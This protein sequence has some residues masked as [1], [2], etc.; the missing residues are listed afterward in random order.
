MKRL[1]ALLIVTQFCLMGLHAQ[2]DSCLTRLAGFAKNISNFN[3]LYPQEKVYLHF[4]NTGY[5]LGDTIWFKAYVVSAVDLVPAFQSKVVYVELLTPEGRVLATRKLKVEDGQCHGEF[6]LDDDLRSG[7]YEVRAYTRFMLNF[8]LGTLFSRVFPV[9]KEPEFDGDYAQRDMKEFY[10]NIGNDNLRQRPVEKFDKV[11]VTFFPEGGHLVNGIPSQVAFKATDKNGQGIDVTG[12]VLNDRNQ[13]ITTFASLHH[14]MGVFNVCPDS[15]NFKV[16][17]N[18]QDKMYTFRL[19]EIEPHGYV[20][21]A[22]S[23]T[24]DHLLLQL[25]KSANFRG[26]TLGISVVCR[27]KVCK[28]YLSDM[29]SQSSIILKI[30]KAE[31]PTGI[32]QITVFNQKGVHLAQRMVFVNNDDYIRIVGNYTKKELK[33]FEKIQMDF[34]L[35]DQQDQPVETTFSLAVR[36][37]ATDLPGHYADNLKSDLLLS[38]DLKGFIEDASY[39]LEADDP[40]H[41]TALDLLLMVQG[42]SRYSWNQMAGKEPFDCRYKSEKG[43][44]IDGRVYGA[45]L[46]D[47]KMKTNAKVMMWLYSE[48]VSPQKGSC[49]TDNEGRFNF[50]VNDFEGKCN[51]TLQATEKSKGKDN[52]KDKGI[53]TRIPLDR[54]ISPLP[55]SFTFFDT[56]TTKRIIENKDSGSLSTSIV[57]KSTAQIQVLKDFRIKAR[58]LTRVNPD[59]VYDVEKEIDD[60][61]DQGKYYPS[62]VW[63]YLL[64]KNPKFWYKGDYPF[65]GQWKYGSNGAYVIGFDERGRWR[66]NPGIPPNDYCHTRPIEEVQRIVISG[67]LTL[68]RKYHVPGELIDSDPTTTILVYPFKNAAARSQKGIRITYLDGYSQSSSFYHPDYSQG[69]LPGDIDYRRTLYWNPDVKSDSTGNASVSFYNNSSCQKM[70]VRAETVTKQGII[71][72][73]SE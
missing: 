18:Y 2:S 67:D 41:R 7:F 11:D 24:K 38:S 64:D 23:K 43:I 15:T 69:V 29:V 42:W 53:W 70:T 49:M 39:Y 14:G 12:T 13:E 27:G 60:L 6:A 28:F 45:T 56:D 36:D 40:T 57:K 37:A 31:L 25:Q 63:D 17:I 48:K 33:P 34:A 50:L 30:P 9:Y 8:D 47:R 71:G 5:Y 26:D 68:C 10:Q 35:S 1:L 72:T 22:N 55:R 73:F 58:K 66:N 32:H 44:V 54:A 51:L 3:N 19:P 21:T 16:K 46:L 62:I 61:I 20:L 65:A 52:N 4:D 59:I